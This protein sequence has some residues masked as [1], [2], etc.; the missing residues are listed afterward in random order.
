[1]LD[2]LDFRDHLRQELVRGGQ[3][4]P[5][6]L[7]D[8]VYRL[9][10]QFD[11]VDGLLG[12]CAADGRDRDVHLDRQ[13]GIATD[14]A[15]RSRLPRSIKPRAGMEPCRRRGAFGWHAGLPR[16]ISRAAG[17]EAADRVRRGHASARDAVVL[18]V[19]DVRRRAV[20]ASRRAHCRITAP[21]STR[22]AHQPAATRHRSRS[23]AT[24]GRPTLRA[25]T[26]QA[27]GG[28]TPLRRAPFAAAAS[29][30]SAG[31]VTMA[32]CAAAASSPGGRSQT[33]AAPSAT[34]HLQTRHWSQ[35]SAIPPSPRRG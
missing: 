19:R 35:I 12:W 3:A 5:G 4:A 1:M 13:T 11:S 29:G 7:H 30:F 25:S 6:V 14:R 26:P 22:L 9:A 27:H 32:C 31:A 24:S 28:T 33:P 16:D 2:A 21:V 34:L 23:S 10:A 8:I 20:E 15:H 18:R 17:R